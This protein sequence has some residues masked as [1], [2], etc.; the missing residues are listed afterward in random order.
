MQLIIQKLFKL[1]TFK[2]LT[3]LVPLFSELNMTMLGIFDWF[4]TSAKGESK[5]IPQ[6]YIGICCLYTKESTWSRLWRLCYWLMILTIR[7]RSGLAP[8]SV[9]PCWAYQKRHS[10]SHRSTVTTQTQNKT[11]QNYYAYRLT[12][13]QWHRAIKLLHS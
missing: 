4:Y 9:R 3:H 13:V 11:R 1:I 12:C 5:D 8:Y 7:A 10:D 6:V 2:K